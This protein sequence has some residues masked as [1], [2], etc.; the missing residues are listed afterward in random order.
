LQFF[1]ADQHEALAR[2]GVVCPGRFIS[3]GAVDPVHDHFL[4]MR[5]EGERERAVAAGRAR[6]MELGALPGIHTVLLSNESVLGE[7]VMPGNP[8]FFPRLDPSVSA[9]RALF[10]GYDVEVV[11]FIRPFTDFIP[12]FYVQHVR[13]GAVQSFE[14]FCAALDGDSLRWTRVVAALVQA[15]GADRV[16]VY[17][18]A[19]LRARPAETCRAAFGPYAP[20]LPDFAAGSYSRNR[21]VGPGM[22]ALYRG[23]N[24]VFERLVPSRHRRAGRRIMRKYIFSTLAPLSRGGKLRPPAVLAAAWQAA[25]A[26]DLQ[27]LGLQPNTSGSSE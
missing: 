3:K 26:A 7:P 20:G 22:L 8:A 25:Y 27:A 17:E 23:M 5:R 16:H 12:S 24:R 14:D 10:D 21:S 11:Y 2:D 4:A 13:K 9:L 1:F 18:H 15:F 19:A 6:L